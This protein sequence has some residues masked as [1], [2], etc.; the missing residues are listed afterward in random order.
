M[1][2][3]HLHPGALGLTRNG[4]HV[5]VLG[6]P[7]GAHLQ[8]DGGAIGL[9]CIHHRLH[10]GQGQV[11]VLHQRRTRPFVA[12]FFGGAAH[13]DVDDLG[14]AFDVVAG[15]F[16]HHLRL[17]ARDLHRNGAALAVMVGAARSLQAVP[18]V[19]A[20][21]DHFAHGIACT[22]LLGQ[23]A[24]RPVCDARHGRRKDGVA[25]LERTNAHRE[26]SRPA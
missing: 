9:G 22:Q 12:H 18:Q 26:E 5:A 17:G 3:D 14:A 19:G 8:G 4:H 20:R 1:H 21:G 7:T 25:C 23:H 2:R 11:F 15:R 10:D 6:A 24:K 16:G 13:V